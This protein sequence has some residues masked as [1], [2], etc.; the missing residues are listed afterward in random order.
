MLRDGHGGGKRVSAANAAGPVQDSDIDNAEAAM[1]GIGQTPLF[2]IRDG[3][4]GLDALLEARGYILVDPVVMMARDIEGLTDIPIPRVTA[5]TI[6]EPLAIMEEIW[7][8]GGIGAARL[9]VMARA[10]V[11]TSIFA[12]WNDKPAGVAFAAVHDG[13]CMVHAVEV[14]PHQRQQGVASWIMRA[15]AHWAKAQGAEQISVLC[16]RANEGAG[17]LYSSLGFDVVGHYHYRQL[18]E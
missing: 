4:A 10:Q 11:K 7:A 17:R 9:A 2:M 5:F 8:K 14:M 6:W 1:R 16:T 12:R 18:S 3:E 13:I 15:A